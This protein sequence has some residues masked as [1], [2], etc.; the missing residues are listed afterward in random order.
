M[1]PWTIGL[2]TQTPLLRWG[3]HE[4]EPLLGAGEGQVHRLRQYH[5]SPG[6]V[7]RMVLQSVKAWQAAGR[8]RQAHWFSLQPQG[9]GRLALEDLPVELHH[10]RLAPDL[11]AAYARTKEKLW[12]DIHGMTPQ[13]FDA[14][15]FRA[16][17]GYNH[18]TSDA[19]M[20]QAHDLDAVYVHDFQLLQVGAMVGLAAPCVLRWHVPF[21]PDLIPRYTRNFLLRM[22]ESYDAVIVS[23]RRD[24]EGLTNAGFRGTVRQV[25]PHTQPADWQPPTSAAAQLFEDNTGLRVDEPVVLC[26]ARMD[27]MKRQDVLLEA[28][29]LLRSGHPKAKVVLVGNGSFSGSRSTGLGLTTS[30]RWR[31]HLEQMANRLGILDRTVFTGWMPDDLVAAAYARADVLVLPSDIE[32]FGLTPFEAWGY[33]KPCIVTTGCG[34]SE[35]VHDGLTGFTV[36]PADPAA[37]ADAL[38]RV[39]SR[40][41]DALRM[42][43]AG[44]VALRGFTAANAAAKEWDVLEAAHRR[45]RRQA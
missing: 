7:S 40:P 44:R 34:A 37:M 3:P 39:L 20:D 18:A 9:P 5:V 26:V 30:G 38:D 23:T 35:V 1:Q 11:M 36:P 25:Y 8:L 12:S 42:G 41:E 31:A 21:N 43:E 22:M 19:M 15:D 33:R 29:A 2:S 14:D 4:Q 27:P 45:F 24:L 13:P 28:M 10:L 32:G 17:M 16:F 6:G